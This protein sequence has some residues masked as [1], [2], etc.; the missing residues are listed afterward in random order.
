VV[1]LEV[2]G[3]HQYACR[4]FDGQRAG[5]NDGVGVVDPLDLHIPDFILFALGY[6]TEVF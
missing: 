3:V 6:E 2:C 1:Y 5:V 4:G